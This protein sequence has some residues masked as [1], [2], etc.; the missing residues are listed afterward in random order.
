[1]EIRQ[2]RRKKCGSQQVPLI[3]A[4]ILLAGTSA[5]FFVF[6]CPYLVSEYHFSIAIVNGVL[7]FLVHVM[8]F[9]ATFTDPGVYPRAPE[10]DDDENDLRQPLYK[11][12]EIGGIT[13]KMKWCETCRF[14]RPPRCSHCSVC[15]NCV[16]VFDHHCPWVDN[17]IGKQ[18]YRYFFFFIFLL[19][20]HILFVISQTVVF[21]MKHSGKPINKI[22]PPIII[23]IISALALFPVV[24][25]ALFHMGLVALG[26]TTNEQVT[27]K[28]GSGHNPFDLGCR[29]NCC[30]ILFG[31]LPPKYLGYKMPKKKKTKEP[32][33]FEVQ[34]SAEPLHMQHIQI[35][36]EPVAERNPKSIVK[37]GGWTGIQTTDNSSSS[38]TRS[39]KIITAYEVTV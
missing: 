2:R 23:L 18:N 9:R 19:S 17:C 21:V 13:V 26:R 3:V 5:L 38:S 6:V 33:P 35:E 7:T 22:I 4:L 28:F 8:F 39:N 16:E 1:M 12:A 34:N 10:S 31:P 25:L 32:K 15:N 36:L 11:N 14:Y 24:G 20:I 37:G 27:G 30:S 29:R